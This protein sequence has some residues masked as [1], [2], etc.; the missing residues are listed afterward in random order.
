MR[1]NNNVHIMTRENN[2]TEEKEL[3]KKHG[4]MGE[5]KVNEDVRRRKKLCLKRGDMKM[6]R[7]DERED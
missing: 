4:E 3:W 5:K 6:E 2:E 7:G 1:Q